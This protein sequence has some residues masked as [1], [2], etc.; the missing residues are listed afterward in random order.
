MKNRFFTFFIFIFLTTVVFGNSEMLC[1]SPWTSPIFFPL[2][3]RN[4]TLTSRNGIA[5]M[6]VEDIFEKSFYFRCEG[7][8]R[9]RL[10]EN[11]FVSGFWINTDEKH[12]V[13]GK[14]KEISETKVQANQHKQMNPYYFQQEDGELLLKVSPIENVKRIGVR[15]RC[16]FPAK[17]CENNF[18][19]DLPLGFVHKIFGNNL[20]FPKKAQFS[21]KA[22]IID[23]NGIS[24]I[25]C[26]GINKTNVQ[27]SSL[28]NE[29]AISVSLS[30]NKMNDIRL[31]W[32]TDKKEDFTTAAYIA[33]WGKKYSFI[34]INNCNIQEIKQIKDLN[35]VVDLS[36][37]VG[38]KNHKRAIT[39]IKKIFT[40]DLME[41]EIYLLKNKKLQPANFKKLETAKTFGPDSWEEIQTIDHGPC[42]IITDGIRLDRETI[43][44]TY[45][46]NGRKP[47]WVIIVG[48]QK[49]NNM[50]KASND[51]YGGVVYL[52]GENF[53]KQLKLQLPDILKSISSTPKL[54]S[55]NDQ[56]CYPI[57]KIPLSRAYYLMPL[58]KQSYVVKQ[59]SG[60]ELIKIN[61]KYNSIKLENNFVSLIAYQQIKMLETI[62][63]APQVL[64]KITELGKNYLIATDYTAFVEVSDKATQSNNEIVK[65]LDSLLNILFPLENIFFSTVSWSNEKAKVRS[66]YAN[67]RILKTAI[68]KFKNNGYALDNLQHD[69]YSGSFEIKSL[70]EKGYL[71]AQLFQPTPL[72][73]YRILGHLN[74][75]FQIICLAHGKASEPHTSIEKLVKNYCLKR[76]LK[77]KNFKIPLDIYGTAPE[78]DNS[79]FLW[80]IKKLM[81]FC[82]LLGFML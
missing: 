44:T 43:K 56:P 34:R 42:I 31:T 36:G 55:E 37:S 81:P 59:N 70:I 82:C 60:K 38:P 68:N 18:H 62:K 39:L 4:V 48:S 22:K 33:P 27:I 20:N 64:K 79:G 77:T 9:F 26:Q 76:N 54:Y 32:E 1:V 35:I 5:S 6:E 12:W 11:A 52:E 13:R 28:E 10:P 57:F 53:A 46:A 69:L 45:R 51:R 67:Q 16:F 80:V 74:E 63:Q 71:R 17:G 75:D 19:L 50:L 61:S 49:V 21:L 14:A 2:L 66:C 78:K 8:Y 23:V 58:K 15:F 30:A 65:N 29:N 40:Y 41:P 7:V 25:Q 24:N 73:E 3:E 47:V 72:C